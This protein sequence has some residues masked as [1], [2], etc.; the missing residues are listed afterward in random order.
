M[1]IGNPYSGRAYGNLLANPRYR[2]GYGMAQQGASSAPV[3]HWTQGLARLAQGLVGKWNMDAGEQEEESKRKER[4]QKLAQALQK[5]QGG[6]IG[7]AMADLA[8]FDEDGSTA[9]QYGMYNQNRQDRLADREQE[10]TRQDQREAERRKWEASQRQGPA[11]I[12]QDLGDRIAFMDR[13]GNVIKEIPKGQKPGDGGPFK[14]NALD[15][16]AMNILLQGDPSSP[17]YAAAY[18]H[19]SSPKAQLDPGT[20]QVVT[21]RPDMSPYR[22][23]G[24]QGAPQPTAQPGQPTISRVGDPSPKAMPPEQAAKLQM[25]QQGINTVQQAEQMLFGPDGKTFNRGLM[26]ESNMPLVGGS[27]PGSEGAGVRALLLSAIEARLRAESGAAVPPEEVRRAAERFMPNAYDSPE[28]ARQKIQ[29]L[30]EGLQGGIGL[31]DPHGV[32]PP[33]NYAPSPL[34]SAQ[35]APLPAAAPPQPAPPPQQPV[36]PQ[37]GAVEDG[38]RFKGGDPADPNSWEPAQ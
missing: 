3:Q 4:A 19:M 25:V 22:Q 34:P 15:A 26:A 29:L 38:F 12:V 7:A 27:M 32:R 28:V 1:T 18:A 37:P 21:I 20:G 10:W 36:M 6:N 2:Y 31:M 24:Q 17:E 13:Q 14:G 30:K 5:M 23:P 11:P 35:Q 16:Q 9:I 8:E 33:G